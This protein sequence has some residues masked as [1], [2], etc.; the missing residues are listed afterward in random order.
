MSFRNLNTIN[1]LN[2][3]DSEKLSYCR[4]N[5]LEKLNDIVSKGINLEQDNLELKGKNYSINWYN[6]EGT[7][8]YFKKLN[9]EKRLNQLLGELIS[10]YF[11]ISSAHYILAKK[12]CEEGIATPNFCEEGFNY[13]RL[14]YFGITKTYDEFETLIELKKICFSKEIYDN[15]VKEIKSI[16]IR[17]FFCSEYDRYD[18]NYLLKEKDGI[19]TSAP[20]FDYENSFNTEVFKKHRSI[21]GSFDID[22]EKFIKIFQDDDDFQ[23]LFNK[24]IDIDMISLLEQLEDENQIII[25]RM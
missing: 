8:Y 23:M 25:N 3:C 12:D 16:L 9:K 22:D 6:I 20:L 18:Y 10:R 24:L 2:I 14:S 5:D 17:D 21:L 19:I 11:G 1:Y 4:D 13:R 7:W 15:L